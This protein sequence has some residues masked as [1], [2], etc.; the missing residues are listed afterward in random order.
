[1][2]SE[3]ALA[4]AAKELAARRQ[5]ALLTVTET[6]G[7]SPASAGQVMAVAA[8]GDAAGTVG[9]G[10]AEH[11]LIQQAVEAIRRGQRIFSF[12]ID[13]GA[14][15]MVCGGAMSGV[16]NVLGVEARL[17]IFGGGHV[18][19]SLAKIAGD[20][21]F[22]VTV[23]EDR[24]EFRDAFPQA[25]YLVCTPEEY[26]EKIPVTST[27]YAV[28]STRGHRSD[29]DALRHCLRHSPR[30]LGMIGSRNKVAT[31]FAQLR[32]EGVPEER[33]GE[34]Y[35]PIGLDV[36][37]EVPAEIAVSILAEILL[38]KNGGSPRHKAHEPE[39]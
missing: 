25:E 39:R 10:A 14:E 35:T 27:T 21:G 3:E 23:V 11:K 20:I 6:Q 9:G 15:G 22:P 17:L 38:V 32:K 5:V 37:S 18:A 34:I 19:Q 1:M 12:F 29:D 33:L 7:S 13:H 24:P 36:A 4:F 28:I 26:G 16:G 31:L 8:S 30:Y 2:K